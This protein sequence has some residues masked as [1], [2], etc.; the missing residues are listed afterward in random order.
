MRIMIRK[1]RSNRFSPIALALASLCLTQSGPV[2]TQAAGIRSQSELRQRGDHSDKEI[3]RFRRIRVE[4]QQVILGDVDPLLVR[5]GNLLLLAGAGGK[6]AVSRD[7]GLT[8]KTTQPIPTD[9]ARVAALAV[10]KDDSFVAAVQS[11][12]TV[13]V[14][15]SNDGADWKRIA[16][17]TTEN[18]DPNTPASLTTLRNG[19]LLLMVGGTS[20]RST[21]GGRIW[22]NSRLRDAAWKAI[23]PLQLS[24]E[25]LLAAVEMTRNAEKR[26]AT[27]YTGLVESGDGGMTWRQSRPITRLGQVPGNLAELPDGRL[28]LSYVEQTDPYGARALVSKDG[29]KSWG[30]DVFVLGAGR[31]GPKNKPRPAMCEPSTGVKTVALPDGTLVSAFDRG[32]SMR[33]SDDAGNQASINIVRWKPEG[34]KKPPLAY[35]GLWT[36]KVDKKGYLDNGMVRMRPDD[37]F[38]GGDYVEE[39]ELMVYRRLP[40][41]QLDF[42]EIGAKGVVI[43][44]H[45]DGSLVFS[46]REPV[47]HRSTDEGRTWKKLADIQLIKHGRLAPW[48]FGVTSQGTFL[49][50]YGIQLPV[51][52]GYIARSDDGGKTWTQVSLD[53][54]PMHRMGHGDSSR[55]I[56]LSDGTIIMSCGNTWAGEGLNH[57]ATHR[58]YSGDVVLRSR[59]DGKTWGDG[60][61]LPPGSCESNF[62]ELPSGKLLIATRYQR[63]AT[64][65]D[66]F[67][68]I[69]PQ[70][71]PRDPNRDGDVP[72]FPAAAEFAKRPWWGKPGVEVGI[73][74]FKNEAVMISHDKGYSFS[75]PELV[76]RLHM[77]S[78]DVV[79][80]TDGRVVMV[81]DHKDA[82][83]GVRALV[84]RDEGRTW[85]K[86]RYV[87]G[88]GRKRAGRASSVALKDGTVYTLYAE[89]GGKGVHAT[90]WKPE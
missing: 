71:V 80:L 69:G 5:S 48:G 1:W 45:P 55:I 66:L 23:R 59:D 33:N 31:Y 16:D 44:R 8:W 86:E 83:H 24:T 34:L 61:V 88:Y 78:A 56:G 35:P 76:T 29:G 42:A 81:Y 13:T 84:S 85:Q 25:R 64:P 36:T 2:A 9:Q 32:K 53:P 39:H 40:A 11:R 77:V 43:C 28:V 10:R 50:S 4:R 21:D 15:S 87:I 18:E 74:R 6:A 37:R 19:T 63:H 20:M 73:G 27:G 68:V 49:Y 54:S 30:D 52:K 67:K 62:L 89:S 79:L 47:I 17:L 60:T 90:I 82:P 75:T 46:S 51:G 57:W 12:K 70:P 3:L 41:E 72:V 14:L 58:G 65:Y 22:T 7:D 38:E 26:N